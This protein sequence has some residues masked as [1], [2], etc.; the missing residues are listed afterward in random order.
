MKT[1]FFSINCN[2]KNVHSIYFLGTYQ[3]SLLGLQYKGLSKSLY[4][5]EQHLKMFGTL[6]NWWSCQ[7]YT[8]ISCLG[9]RVLFCFKLLFCFN[10]SLH[11]H[12]SHRHRIATWQNL[13][14]IRVCPKVS[15]HISICAKLYAQTTTR[16]IQTQS[17]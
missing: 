2:I 5:V 17:V 3:T 11:K 12:S 8:I 6:Q 9:V 14:T 13:V 16:C 15:T 4:L 10:Y 1:C 7:L